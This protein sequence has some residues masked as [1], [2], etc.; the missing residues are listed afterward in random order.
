MVVIKFTHSPISQTFLQLY[1][2]ICLTDSMST[3]LVWVRVS[4]LYLVQTPGQ[5]DLAQPWPQ[6]TIPS[7]TSHTGYR[8]QSYKLHIGSSHTGSYRSQRHKL[9]IGNSDTSNLGS[10]DRSNLGSSDT[11]YLGFSDIC[12]LQTTVIQ[13][14]Q[15]TV[16]ELTQEQVTHSLAGNT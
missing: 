9:L 2:L 10:S 1:K 13:V 14:V 5:P 11:N 8:Q 7:T 4:I 12:Y 15:A 16:T 6:D 3:S